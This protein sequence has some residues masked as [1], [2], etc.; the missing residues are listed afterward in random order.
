[1]NPH[2]LEITFKLFLQRKKFSSKE[3]EGYQAEILNIGGPILT[4]HIHKLFN[5]VVKQGFPTPWNQSLI[6]YI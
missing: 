6:I 4:P 3:I 1:M 5:S 2:I